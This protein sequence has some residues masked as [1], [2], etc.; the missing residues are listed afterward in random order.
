MIDR[1]PGENPLAQ[2]NHYQSIYAYDKHLL[3]KIGKSSSST[4]NARLSPNNHRSLAQKLSLQTRSPNLHR[5]TQDPV[6]A[7]DSATKWASSPPTSAISSTTRPSWQDFSM[8]LRSPRS[9]SSQLPKHPEADFL[10]SPDTR[11]PPS[12][13]HHASFHGLEHNRNRSERGS[14]DSGMNS[15]DAE[16]VADDASLSSAQCFDKPRPAKHY[17]AKKRALS[18]SYE[19][20]AERRMEPPQSQP[21]SAGGAQSTALRRPYKAGSLSSTASSTQLSSHASSYLLSSASSVTSLSS[22]DTAIT[23]AM[24]QH[25]IFES[26]SQSLSLQPVAIQP[27]RQASDLANA[28]PT[29]LP[30][31]MQELRPAPSRIGNHYI[32]GCCPKKP[33]KFDTEELLR[34]VFEY[35][36]CHRI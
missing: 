32:C 8:D 11:S 26:P 2:Q 7:L 33:R 3:Q 17:G 34:C 27:L 36:M 16:S 28:A 1:L 15:L 19:R 18:P 25:S 22:I 20:V 12:R 10:L 30:S 5:P 9:E 23:S 6:A 35:C 29:C 31:S 24:P 4:D 13:T 14:H 21:S